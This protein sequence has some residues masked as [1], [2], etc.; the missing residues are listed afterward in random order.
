VRV[1]TADPFYFF[2]L[3][4]FAFLFFF[5][6]KD[7]SAP[8][9][10]LLT[11]VKI[12]PLT[13][14]SVEKLKTK[15]NVRKKRQ[16]LA[17]LFEAKFKHAGF[18]G[19]VLIAQQG[20]IIYKGSFGLADFKTKDSLTI[21][22]AFQLGSSS[23][24]LT[25]MALI[26]LHEKG[27]L[28]YT[29]TI[30]EFFP[31]FPYKGITIKQLLTHRSGLPNYMYFCDSLYCCP[32]KPMSNDDLLS[33]MCE[34]K[35]PPYALPNKKF[36]YCNT[37]YSLLVNIVEKVSGRKFGAF[38]KEELFEPLGMV[39]T[40][41][42]DRDSNGLHK[43]KTTGHK[44]NKKHYDDDYLDGIL[45]DKN[46]F[47]TVDDLFLFDQALYNGKLIKKESLDEAFTGASKEHPGK[48]NYGYG[49]RMIEEKNGEKIIYHN[50]WW[51]GYN[52]VFYRRLKDKTTIIILSNKITYGI[53]RVDDVLSILDGTPSSSAGVVD[54]DK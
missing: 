41:I 5:S 3:I 33:L 2:L 43:N 22:S 1:K 10:P 23:K 9:P 35:P 44:A 34:K 7:S 51:H 21:G 8:P 12:S 37:N 11:P 49:W 18:N 17:S 24:P 20:I 32:D 13:N 53:Y 40:W 50:G 26:L 29:Q 16:E 6:C 14:D 39:H 28:N 30:D 38:M 52:N 48:R 54:E 15:L 19:N 47:T 45:G 25:A 31:K 46:I 4:H 42:S 36:E 27:L